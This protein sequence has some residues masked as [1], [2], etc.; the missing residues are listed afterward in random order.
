VPS[1]AT[2]SNPVLLIDLGNLKGQCSVWSFQEKK[3]W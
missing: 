3:I 1:N 2:S